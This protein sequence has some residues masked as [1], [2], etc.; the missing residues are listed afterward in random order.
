MDLCEWESGEDLGGV[1]GEKIIFRIY[2]ME[3]TSI[4]NEEEKNSL[5]PTLPDN[6]IYL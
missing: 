1:V 4:F 3:K 6:I 2:C 5:G